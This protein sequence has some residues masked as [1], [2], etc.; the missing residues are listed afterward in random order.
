MHRPCTGTNFTICRLYYA[1]HGRLLVL[2]IA[3]SENLQK[4][5]DAKKRELESYKDEIIKAINGTSSFGADIPGE[6]IKVT[7]TKLESLTPELGQAK[8]KEEELKKSSVSIQAEYDKVMT[9]AELNTSSSIEAKKM[10]PRQ[11]I[12]RVNIGRDYELEL[13]ICVTQFFDFLHP[14]GDTSIRC[15]VA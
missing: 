12:D 15:H 13:N 1:F 3:A 9:W 7:R 5:S 4:V 10:I 14:D 2:A 8:A 6:M 11:L